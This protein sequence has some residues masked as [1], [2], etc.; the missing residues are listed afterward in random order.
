MGMEKCLVSAVMAVYEE[1]WTV[2][3]TKDGDSKRFVGVS[4]ESVAVCYCD[5]GGN[6]KCERRIAIG[7]ILCR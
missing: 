7:T 6:Q 4:V 1:A 5:G 3:R 2:V